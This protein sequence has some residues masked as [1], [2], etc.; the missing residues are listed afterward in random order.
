MERPHFEERGLHK[1]HQVLYRPFLVGLVRPTQLHPYPHLQ[2]GV[3]KDRVP[4][5]HLATSIPF[6]CDGFWSIEHT[7]QGTPAPTMKMLGQSAYQALYGLVWHQT[8]TDVAGVLQTRS[9]EMHATEGAIDELDVVLSEVV[10]TEFSGQAFETDHGLRR[11]G[12]QGSHQFIQ[13]RLATVIARHPN[14]PKNFPR[15]Q[16]GFFLQDIDDQFPEIRDDTG[17]SNVAFC[18]LSSVVDI[19]NRILFRDAMYGSRRYSRQTSHFRLRMPGL[20]QDFY[21][22]AF[23][24]SQHPPPSALLVFQEGAEGDYFFRRVLGL[25]EF[26]E[27]GMPEFSE[28]AWASA[29]PIHLS[30]KWLPGPG[31]LLRTVLNDCDGRTRN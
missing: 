23:Q 19:D 7:E 22:V 10:L 25:T 8:H 11:L 17:S 12:T 4:F 5:R 6:Q 21:F 31:C 20:K 27:L 30:E 29:L 18:P 3:G 13:S 14:L 28:P 9:K 24:H 16:I 15:G 26:P 1:F 2:R